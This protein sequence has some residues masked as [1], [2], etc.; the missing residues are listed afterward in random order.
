MTTEDREDIKRYFG[1]V[2]EGLES[3]IQLV[4]EGVALANDR[5]DRL[6]RRMDG[7]DTRM[8]R[9]EIEVRRGFAEMGSAIK[10]SHSQLDS[11]LTRLET[12]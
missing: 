10:L 7:F 5:I 1:V 3:K 2:A 8:D 6:D 11:R 4:A 9:L 12:A